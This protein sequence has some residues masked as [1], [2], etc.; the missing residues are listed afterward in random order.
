M[1]TWQE[2]LVHMM[3]DERHSAGIACP[4][5]GYMTFRVKHKEVQREIFDGL[6]RWVP[7]PPSTELKQSD[8]FELLEPF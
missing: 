6:A 2:A 4:V 5:N 7:E 1:S 3:E 8:K